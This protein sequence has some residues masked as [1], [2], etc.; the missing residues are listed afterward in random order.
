MRIPNRLLW[1]GNTHGIRSILNCFLVKNI[2]DIPVYVGLR[3]ERR[4]RPDLALRLLADANCYSAGCFSGQLRSGVR[5]AR[6]SDTN[7]NMLAEIDKSDPARSHTSDALGYMIARDF[8]MRPRS[9]EMPGWA[10]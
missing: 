3:L 5:D 7:G 2:L 8:A 6:E 4:Y 1:Y 9:G 10:R